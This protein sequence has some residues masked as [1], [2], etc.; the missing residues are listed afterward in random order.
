MIDFKGL[1]VNHRFSTPVEELF[2]EESTEDDFITKYNRIKRKVALKFDPSLSNSRV[3]QAG[4]ISDEELPSVDMTIEGLKRVKDEFPFDFK[5]FEEEEEE[6]FKST[7]SPL[8]ENDSLTVEEYEELIAIQK[9]DSIVLA[10]YELNYQTEKEAEI[11][12]NLEMIKQDFSTLTEE[13]IEEHIDLIDEYYKKNMDY[14]VLEEI[15]S[16]EEEITNSLTQSKIQRSQKSSAI[17]PVLV[18]GGLVADAYAPEMLAFFGAADIDICTYEKVRGRYG[19]IAGNI[20]AATASLAGVAAEYWAPRYLPIAGRERGNEDK[21][22]AFRHIYLNAL[23]CKN[24][25]TLSSSKKKRN[26][27]ARFAMNAFYRCDSNDENHPVGNRAMDYHSDN[28]GISIYNQLTKSI[29]IWKWTIG[30]REPSYTK[31]KT[32]IRDLI[33]KKGVFIVKIHPDSPDGYDPDYVHNYS[34]EEIKKLIDNTIDSS[35]P[36]YKR[37]PITAP[38]YTYQRY[39]PWYRRRYRRVI[40]YPTFISKDPNLTYNSLK[41]SYR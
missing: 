9:Q 23:L 8:F 29:K 3:Q 26:D 5:I 7:A 32:H 34:T 4:D 17:G 2:L 36:V 21:Q 13:Q 30:L 12:E 14:V 16:H 31:L 25:I 24:Y 20:A 37:G 18:A 6:E 38:Y 41:N 22:D 1:K 35:L 19:L 39:G 15:A 33:N 40:N 27:F 10:A 11:E 28:L